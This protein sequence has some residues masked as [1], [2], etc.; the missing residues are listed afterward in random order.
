MQNVFSIKTIQISLSMADGSFAGNKKVIEGLATQ[1]HVVKPGLPETNS[2]LVSIWGLT[3]EDM[4]GLTMLAF[5][6]LES[7]R[8]LIE[9]RAG[10]AGGHLSLLFKGHITHAYADFNQA[11]APAMCI[12]ADTGSYP[13]Q[14]AAPVLTIMNEALCEELFSRFAQ[15]CGYAYRNQGVWATVKNSWFPGSPLEKAIKLARDIDCEIIIDDDTMITMPKGKPRAQEAVLLSRQTGLIGYPTFNQDGISCRAIY[16]PALS[17]GGLVRVE[18]IVPRASGL[19]RI[20]KLSH[21][22]SAYMPGAGSWE[23]NLE[24]AYNE[25]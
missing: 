19:W 11:P 5:K 1:A 17:Y 2:A 24:A 14:M 16:N 18:S 20:T 4:A 12:E 9:I 10:E 23:T 22:V 21:S 15:E 6:P 25:E 3:Y 7:E 13:Q 8:N